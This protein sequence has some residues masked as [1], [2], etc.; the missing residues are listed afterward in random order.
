MEKNSFHKS[1]LN[2][3]RWMSDSDDEV[4]HVH[5]KQSTKK[6]NENENIQN[7]LPTN[8]I[9]KANKRKSPQN[10]DFITPQ[11]KI[12]QK[13]FTQETIETPQ[14]LEFQF[15][16]PFS[17]SQTD[18]SQNSSCAKSFISENSKPAGNLQEI[19]QISA[20][21]QTYESL[22]PIVNENKQ[23]IANKTE[24][25][26]KLIKKHEDKLHEQEIQNNKLVA[27]LQ[28]ERFELE[29]KIE[30]AQKELQKKEEMKQTN[31]N[32]NKTLDAKAKVKA[33][34]ESFKA[35][36]AS[37]RVLNQILSNNILHE[38]DFKEIYDEN[39]FSGEVGAKY[40]ELVNLIENCF[41]AKQKEELVFN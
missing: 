13:S 41:L 27:V 20:Y 25:L 37:I 34:K 2:E 4:I 33:E 10:S 1:N 39:P 26:N 11:R 16:T 21:K 30:F 24:K 35:V 7:I 29:Q 18:F 38:D 22:K 15:S 12:I 3:I 36:S 5:V 9:I 40:K 6:I 32:Y 31:E 23:R 28:K 8:E 14:S 19:T 17:Q